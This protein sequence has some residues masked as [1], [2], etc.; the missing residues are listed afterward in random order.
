MENGIEVGHI[1]QL[2]NKY[3]ESMGIDYADETGKMH[4]VQMGCYGIGMTRVIGATIEQ[5]NDENG[6]IWPKNIAPYQ[7]H[8]LGL[9]LDK[10]EEM[11]RK[12]HELYEELKKEGIEVLFDERNISAGKKFADADL[13]G[14]PIRLT[15]SARSLESGGL[16]WKERDQKDAKI[17]SEKDLIKAIQSYYG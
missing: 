13:I 12:A 5:M 8:L 2:G 6:M 15:M 14:I 9:N 16:E 10:D 1:F 3:S 4:K 11:S 7:V 17:V